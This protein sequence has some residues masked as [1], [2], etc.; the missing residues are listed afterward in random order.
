MLDY[1]KSNYASRNARRMAGATLLLSTAALL[2]VASASA[3][4]VASSP[5]EETVG[6]TSGGGL[7][8]IIVTA[9]RRAQSVQET[10]ISALSH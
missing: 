7:D 5:T 9:E 8:V 2:P 3:Q 1:R 4:E 10:P 6:A